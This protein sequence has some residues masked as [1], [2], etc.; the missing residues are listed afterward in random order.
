MKAELFGD[1]P[2]NASMLTQ[3]EWRQLALSIKAAFDVGAVVQPVLRAAGLNRR[4]V[5]VGDTLSGRSAKDLV[6]VLCAA[7][8]R[9]PRRRN[10][11]R[12]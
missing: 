2:P 4:A 9:V 3:R 7:M 1:L 10:R 12:R 5:Y 11:G 8:A 6:P